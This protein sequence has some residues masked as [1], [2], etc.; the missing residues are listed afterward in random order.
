MATLNIRNVP[1]DVVDA[2]KARARQKGVS[3]NTE[4][5][6]TLASTARRRSL[7]EVFASID[8][9]QQQ[10][11]RPIDFD[12]LME[13]MRRDRDERDERIWRAAT[14]PSADG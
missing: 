9:L 7:D 3:L 11:P 1:E 10:L 14:R 12:E 5:V 8:R 13:Q 2:L 6:Q 4:V